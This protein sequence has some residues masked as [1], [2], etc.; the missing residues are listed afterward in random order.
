MP[1]LHLYRYDIYKYM[2]TLSLELYI[3]SPS[4][5]DTVLPF[6]SFSTNVPGYVQYWSGTRVV[7]NKTR[8]HIWRCGI[9]IYNNTTTTGDVSPL[10]LLLYPWPE[11]YGGD[12]WYGADDFGPKA[13]DQ[14]YLVWTLTLFTNG[15]FRFVSLP[16]DKVGNVESQRQISDKRSLGCLV[17]H[18]LKFKFGKKWMRLLDFIYRRV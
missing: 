15:A 17:G 7:H 10:L 8:Q 14:R 2:V 5:L 1:C 6:F 9:Y 13:Q 18:F 11:V 4:L 12:C 16:H 3:Y